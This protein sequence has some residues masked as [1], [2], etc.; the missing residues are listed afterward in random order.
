MRLVLIGFLIILTLV[1]I[2]KLLFGQGCPADVQ[3]LNKGETANCSGYLF[4]PSKQEELKF[5]RQDYK[6]LQ[7]EVTILKQQKELYEANVVK[8]NEIIT[9]EEQKSELWRAKAEDSSKKY[10]ESEQY[11]GT[12]DAWF[13]GGGIVATLTTGL[14]VGYL[15]KNLK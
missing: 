14:V 2:P 1:V 7:Q 8:L 9:K 3:Y 6:L 13:F 12:R 11:R 15:V 5:M 10:M 4:S